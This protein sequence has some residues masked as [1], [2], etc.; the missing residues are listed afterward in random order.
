MSIFYKFR[1]PLPTD[2]MR[3]LDVRATPHILIVALFGWRLLL[4]RSG[5]R[6]WVLLNRFECW[7]YVLRCT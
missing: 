2:R 3:L 4:R 6:W 7:K 5:P 1:R